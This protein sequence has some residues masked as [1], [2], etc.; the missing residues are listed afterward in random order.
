MKILIA[1]DI[2][3]SAA[4][5][6]QLMDRFSAEG[7]DR[8]LL[9]GDVLYH[10]PRN[11]LPEEYDPKSVTAML[12]AIK[13]KVTGVRGNCDAEVDQMVL[14]F[15]ILAEY[16]LLSYNGLTIYA[17]H[18]HHFNINAKPD[19]PAGTVLLYGHTHV[20]LNTESDGMICLNP[21]SVSLPKSG[22]KR[23]YMLLT[24][25]GFFWKT[26]SGETYDQR[27]I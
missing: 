14:E 25:E 11:D 17:T 18:G 12:N 24:E 6:R 26:L 5:C 8:M 7:A 22:S 13:E 15:P 9:L 1:S 27:R 3:G 16:M 4:C 23:G 21:G 20:P 19:V 10:G 2:H